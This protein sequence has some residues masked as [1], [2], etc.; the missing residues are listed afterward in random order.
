MIE[1]NDRHPRNEFLDSLSSPELEE[2]VKAM[3]TDCPPE[4]HAA[5]AINLMQFAA[6]MGQSETPIHTYML[7]H[8]VEPSWQE[9][10]GNR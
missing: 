2:K 5:L 6:A 10:P 8:C 7:D 3:M 9:N 4:H 1:G